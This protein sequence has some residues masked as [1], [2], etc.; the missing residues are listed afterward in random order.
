[1]RVVLDTNVIVSGAI[2]RLG[3]AGPIL[4][5]W[6]GQRFTLL[7]S[8]DLLSEIERVLTYPHVRR[9]ITWSSDEE[10]DFLAYLTQAAS[11]VHPTIRLNN[12]SDEPDNRL[13][14]AA[15][16]GAAD[17][18]VSGETDVLALREFE[19]ARIVTPAAFAAMLQTDM[20]ADTSE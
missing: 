17:F 16:A 2:T 6:R 3:P 10:R 4:A 14:E 12:V 13:L 15:S 18:I 11:L 1:V 19:G 5:F 20:A 8:A 9:Y 7:I